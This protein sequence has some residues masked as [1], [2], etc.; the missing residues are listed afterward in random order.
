[1]EKTGAAIGRDAAELATEGERAFPRIAQH[2]MMQPQLQHFRAILLR[3]RDG[4]QLGHGFAIHS[5]FGVAAGAAQSPFE[6]HS[7]SK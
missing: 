5:E 4:I 1:M 7:L 6:S 3:F 2:E